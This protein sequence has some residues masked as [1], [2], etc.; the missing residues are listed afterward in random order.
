MIAFSNRAIRAFTLILETQVLCS[1]ETVEIGFGDGQVTLRAVGQGRRHKHVF[2]VEWK[3][4]GLHLRTEIATCTCKPVE[5]LAARLSCF[6]EGK[7]SGA[8][9]GGGMRFERAPSVRCVSG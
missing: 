9:E 2:V 6:S 1:W 3:Q 4:E 7:S 8:P 5:A